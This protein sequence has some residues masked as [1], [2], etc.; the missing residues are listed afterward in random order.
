MLRLWGAENVFEN[1]SSSRYP[2]TSTEELQSLSPDFLLLSSE[3]FPFTPEHK[4]QWAQ[5]L[6]NTKVIFVDGEYFSWYGS[7]ML[8]LPDYFNTLN[9]LCKNDDEQLKNAGHPI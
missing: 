5:K 1:H 9:D 3:P 6:P 8:S 7:R 4:T 2:V